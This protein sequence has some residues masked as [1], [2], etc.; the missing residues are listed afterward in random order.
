MIRSRS[1]AGLGL[2]AAFLLP[3]APA[4][5]D[6]GMWTFDNFPLA[7]VN[8]AYG[9]K[10]DQKWLDRV[11]AASVRLTT[12]CSASVVSKSGLVFTNHHC[13]VEC[14][15]DL[16]SGDKDFVQDGFTFAKVG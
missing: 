1:A 16:S 4:L 8:A 14:V 10:L 3:A 2:A 13:V 12:G 15:Q 9:L 6:E 11:Q 7:K 5:A